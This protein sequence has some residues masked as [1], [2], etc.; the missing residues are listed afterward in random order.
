MENRDN[1]ARG[2]P[3]T[4]HKREDPSAATHIVTKVE[5]VRAW[6]CGGTADDVGTSCDDPA[7]FAVSPC[8]IASASAIAQ[9]SIRN[10]DLLRRATPCRTADPPSAS[11]TFR[12]AAPRSFSRRSA[13]M[14]GHSTP[15]LRSVAIEPHTRSVIQRTNDS[16]RGPQATRPSLL[17]S[18]CGA[19]GTSALNVGFKAY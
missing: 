1:S 11:G 8:R 2:V 16:D 17:R 18:G 15:S 4:T 10:R 14:A 9:I 7:A 19:L 12:L 13:P 6:V 5:P 3:K